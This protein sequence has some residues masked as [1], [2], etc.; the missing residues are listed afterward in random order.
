MA[1]DA[2]KQAFR[3]NLR[4]AWIARIDRPASRLAPLFAG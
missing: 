2:S 3:F 4:R 1:F